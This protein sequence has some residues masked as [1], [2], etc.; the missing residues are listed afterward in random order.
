MTT[1][2]DPREFLADPQ[3]RPLARTRR[4]DITASNAQQVSPG[5]YIIYEN[6]T[7]K[8]QVEIVRYLVPFAM[9]RTDIGTPQESFQMIDPM[10]GN[11]HFIFSPRVNSKTVDNIDIDNNAP[12]TAAAA[13]NTDRPRRGGINFIS[14]DPWV[15]SQRYNPLFAIPVTSKT[16][17]QVTFQL[18]PLSQTNPIPNPYQIGAGAKR[19]DFAGVVVAGVVLPQQ[20]Y[21]QLQDALNKGQVSPR[22]VVDMLDAIQKGGNAPTMTPINRR[23]CP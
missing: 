23:S 11:G 3:V 5:E 8:G 19:V 2:I 22:D 17:F 18:A 21:G 4:A 14:R 13:S 10:Q 6:E 7:A 20:L 12:S 16:V 9:E 15:D 1:A